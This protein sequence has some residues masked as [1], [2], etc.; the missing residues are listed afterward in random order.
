ME[1]EIISI[2]PFPPLKWDGYFWSGEVTLP[3]WAGFQTCRGPYAS[4][5]SPEPSDGTARLSV[6]PL[7]DDART[8]PTPE[9]AAAFQNLLHHEAEVAEAVLQA[10]VGYYPGEKEA[11]LDAFDEG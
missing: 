10:L 7:D 8:R 2:P 1:E 3:S 4:V 11:Y 6:E 5:S 9:Q